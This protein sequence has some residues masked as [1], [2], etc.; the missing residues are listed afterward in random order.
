LRLSVLLLAAIA[1]RCLSAFADDDAGFDVPSHFA[2]MLSR[3]TSGKLRLGFE[4]RSRF[5]R[6]TGQAFGATP[7]LDFALLRT[8]V[9]LTYQPNSWLKFSSMMQDA[10]APG[11]GSPA[12]PNFRDS[13]DLQEAY[14]EAAG[15]RG[16]GFGAGR[17]MFNYGDAR[18]IGSPQW[19]NVTRTY[20]HAR[21]FYRQ[22][23]GK[24]EF[25]FLSPV[26]VRP[27]SFNK[28]AL[29]DRVWGTYNSFPKA[30]RKSLIEIYVLRHDQNRTA[31]FTGGASASGTDRLGVN[32]FGGRWAYPFAPGW[33]FIVEGILQ[34][35]KVGPARHRAGAWSSEVQRQFQV[36][37]RPL[38]I[39]MEYKYASGTEDP[40][41]PHHTSTFDQLYPANHDKFGHEDLFGWRNIQN[42]RSLAA[43]AVTPAFRL[44]FMYDSFWLASP[45]DALYNGAG[46][47]IARSPNGV[48]GRYVGQEFDSFLTIKW[49]HFTFGGGYGHVVP[50]AFLRN[51]TP[52]IGPNFLYFFQSYNL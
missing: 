34:N 2:E 10:R 27:N 48:A 17:A 7:D 38:S 9:A 21:L 42:I 31:G 25:L 41:D 16:L 49:R 32:S 14:L 37:R 36:A 3:E 1:T 51:T 28:P 20:D 19:A 43:Y 26:Q 46:R 12:P 24:L 50:G 33:N 22:E 4:F 52:G 47:P 30:W 13:A 40:S 39:S 44:N 11:Y 8:R 18:L 35:G 6:R 29:G 23:W 45:R 15:P 5:E